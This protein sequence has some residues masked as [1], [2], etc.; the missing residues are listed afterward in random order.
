MR[1]NSVRYFFIWA[2]KV[3]G[4]LGNCAVGDAA[5]VH[6]PGDDG[7]RIGGKLPETGEETVKQ[8]AVC[9]AV[10]G[11]ADFLADW[12]LF[13]GGAVIDKGMVFFCVVFIKIDSF[14]C[15]IRRSRFL[16]V[17]QKRRPWMS[18]GIDLQE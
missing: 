18:C 2:A 5:A 1:R 6:P 4:G 12:D 15:G 7:V 17:E 3:R 13:A 16:S 8:V 14:G 9:L 10:V 11:A